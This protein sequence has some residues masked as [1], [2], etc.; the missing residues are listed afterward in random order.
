M[1]TKTV[2]FGELCG[3]KVKNLPKFALYTYAPT[4][5]SQV[6]T[7]VK[8]AAIVAAAVAGT[9]GIIKAI[10]KKNALKLFRKLATN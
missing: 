9:V 5:V 4:S 1:K 8:E 2:T 3:K 10:K 7:S 6:V